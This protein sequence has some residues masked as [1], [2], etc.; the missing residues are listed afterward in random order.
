MACCPAHNDRHPSLE[1]WEDIT[2]GH[3]GIMCYAGCSHQAICDAL[4]IDETNLYRKDT[5]FKARAPYANIT[6]QEL[7]R[8]KIID[9]RFLINLDI[10]EFKGKIRITYFNLDGSKYEHSRFR[11]ALKAKDGTKWE[12]G[13]KAIPYGLERLAIAREAGYLVIPEGESDC[14]TLWRHNMPALGIAGANMFNCLQSEHVAAFPPVVYIVK[15]PPEKGK[16][17]AGKQF[18]HGTSKR[19]ADLGYQGKVLVV[20]LKA[21]HEVKDPND[22]H[23]K[24]HVQGR[25]KDFSAELW[26]AL[27]AATPIGG[28]N[29]SSSESLLPEIILG[30]Q[31]RDVTQKALDALHTYEAIKRRM[32]VHFSMLSRVVRDEDDRPIVQQLNVASL[33]GDLSSSADFFRTKRINPEEVTMIPVSPSNE[34]AEQ[35]LAL[36]P[37]DWKFPVLKGVTEAPVVAP[38][39][40][41][42]DQPGYDK[43]LKVYYDPS[44]DLKGLKVPE[45]VT[46]EDAKNAA[47]LL[48]RLIEEFPF[49]GQADKA[50]MMGLFITPFIR[51][52]FKGD[53]QLALLDATNPGTGKTFLA[54]LLA[55]IA[56]GKRTE[57]RSQKGDDDEWR[58]FILAVLLKCPQVVLI[59]NVRGTLA[60]VSLEAALTSETISDRLLGV[61]KDVTATNTAVWVVTGNN[62][63]IGGDLSR[64][65]FRIRLIANDANPDERDNYEIPQI[66][67][68]CE[69]HRREFVEAILIMIKAWF[70]AGKPAP[71]TKISKADSFGNWMKMVGG[72]LDYAG[73]EGWQQNREELRSKN[74]EEAKEWERFLSAWHNR[75]DSN[76]VKTLDVQKDVISGSPHSVAFE[77][78]SRLFESLPSYLAKKFSEKRESFYL[79]LGHSLTFRKQ[80]VFGSEG[81]RIEDMVDSHTGNKVWRVTKKEIENKPPQTGQCINNQSGS[82]GGSNGYDKEAAVD[83]SGSNPLGYREKLKYSSLDTNNVSPGAWV[84]QTTAIHCKGQNDSINEVPLDRS[85]SGVMTTLDLMKQS[86]ICGGL[87]ST[88]KSEHSKEDVTETSPNIASSDILAE[89]ALPPMADTDLPAPVDCATKYDGFQCCGHEP[90]TYEDVLHLDNDGREWCSKCLAH[91]QLM[92][93]GER[94]GYPAIMRDK[95]G[96]DIFVRAGQGAWLACASRWGHSL[97]SEAL[98]IA[99]SM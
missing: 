63:L 30:G 40:S 88:F 87:N 13:A 80:T 91:C 5:N 93:I 17:D 50:N 9:P 2:D 92:N 42:I 78:D 89:D 75:Y 11:W 90:A 31:L 58:K 23:K 6:L 34:V 29:T 35:I 38:D 41:I 18:G 60:S 61:S 10:T 73:I 65:C 97:V 1:I 27:D 69:E 37:S 47:K 57:A 51:H 74:N 99:L 49:E 70:Q 7:G 14:W 25:L 44:E 8:D 86:P 22:L 79:S 21:S 43:K 96:K 72:I 39:G 64:R 3:A 33:K 28:A 83:C 59:D 84:V 76:W 54:Q 81:F 19:L 56:T 95:G 20:D 24:L 46:Q 16:P 4:S 77:V 26:K 32:F 52:A 53:I 98:Q 15:E 94:L 71:K 82:T 12:K 68:Y 62:L 85:A 67:D 36:P 66:L 55:I 48:S 45:N